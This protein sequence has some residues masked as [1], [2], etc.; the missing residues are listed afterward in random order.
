MSQYQPLDRKRLPRINNTYRH[1]D[2]CV[3]TLFS[4]CPLPHPAIISLR[5]P[6]LPAP[7][8]RGR[9]PLLL[10]RLFERGPC[11]IF[12]SPHLMFDTRHI[13][14][15]AEC[16]CRAIRES[17]KHFICVFWPK[18]QNRSPLLASGFIVRRPRLAPPS[19][20]AL[21]AC[22]GYNAET[23]LDGVLVR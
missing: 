10:L 6:R 20:F 15:V 18:D 23:N 13:G 5:T 11:T 1:K 22:F 12:F 9:H 7:R 2:S 21:H 16:S 4:H 19:R 14:Y 8:R 3:S 17:L